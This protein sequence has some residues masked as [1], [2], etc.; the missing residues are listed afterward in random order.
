MGIEKEKDK[1][2]KKQNKTNRRRGG[3]YYDRSCRRVW[4]GCQF[5]PQTIFNS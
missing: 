2:R 5:R 3:V 4:D 1:T